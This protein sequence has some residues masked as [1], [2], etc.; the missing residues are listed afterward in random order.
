MMYG[1][2]ETFNYFQCSKCLCLQILEIPQ[3]MSAYYPS[4]YYSFQPYDGKK[5]KGLKG[6]LK[7]KFYTSAIFRANPL[8]RI[9]GRL[10]GTDIYDCLKDIPV[11]RST[12]ILDV[13]CG[14]GRNFLFPMAEIGFTHLLGCDPFIDEPIEYTNGLR[15]ENSEVFVRNETYDIITYHHS[16]EHLPNPREHLQK[17]SSLLAENGVL[18]IRIPTVSSF[19]WE[20][21]RENWV[22]LDAPRHFFLHS[23]ESMQFLAENNGFN[24]SKIEYDSTY[25]QFTGSEGYIN[26]IP[27]NTPKAKTLIKKLNRKLRERAYQ[28]KANRLNRKHR[29]DQAIFYLRL[30]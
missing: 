4:S 20:H 23:E 9:L 26:D 12:K 28:K 29:G 21:Y 13:G 1:L 27:L 2:R 30:K 3:D 14:N 8:Q 6:V 7:K 19:A 25:F 11:D 5:F 15:I 10:A 18:I 17:L 22:Q 16:F 24:L